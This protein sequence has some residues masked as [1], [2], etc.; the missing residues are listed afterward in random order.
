MG[1]R[2]QLPL[3]GVEFSEHR[4]AFGKHGA[5]GKREA[6]LRQIT[7][8]GA[9]GDDERA[10]VEAVQAG[11]NLHQR[12]F[13]GAVPAHQ[14]DAVAGRDQPVGVFEKEFVAET[15]SGAGKLDHGL[16]SS[17]HKKR[18]MFTR[19]FDLRVR[20]GAGVAAFRILAPRF[21]VEVNALESTINHGFQFTR[22]LHFAAFG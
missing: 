9:L 6:I 14:A 8:R 5:A 7:S 13:A 18:Q 12:G 20:G 3:H 1:E 2:F 15:F 4:H 22:V 21:A 17:S 19:P 16:D 10:V 11:E